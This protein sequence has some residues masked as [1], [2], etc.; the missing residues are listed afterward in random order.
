MKTS[1]VGRVALLLLALMALLGLSAC[2]EEPPA[3][4]PEPTGPVLTAN[5]PVTNL[6]PNGTTTVT[7]TGKNFDTVG[8]P[9]I[10]PPLPGLPTGVYLVFGS[11]GDNWR[12]S[13]GA[14]GGERD[15]HFQR[16]PV[17]QVSYDY[18]QTSGF[19]NEDTLAQLVLMDANGNFSVDIEITNA[20]FAHENIGIFS[21]GAAGVNK[22]DEELFVPVTFA[23]PAA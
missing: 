10:R 8:G 2:V 20:D 18:A 12:P 17:P 16:W 7:V 19:W 11:V 14:G 21:Y 4:E 3:P 1:R 5:I 15:V 22:A 6:D 9:G 13:E 23:A